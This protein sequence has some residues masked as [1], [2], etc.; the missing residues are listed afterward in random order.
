MPINYIIM[1][2]KIIKKKHTHAHTKMIINNVFMFVIALSLKT[3]VSWN[4]KF[5]KIVIKT[6]LC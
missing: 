4:I 5:R 6:K 2:V 1:C 3:I